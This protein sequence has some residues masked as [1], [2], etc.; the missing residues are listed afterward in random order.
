MINLLLNSMGLYEH[1]LYEH[2][3]REDCFFLYQPTKRSL[4]LFFYSRKHTGS[5]IWLGMNT[6]EERTSNVCIF[7]N[8]DYIIYSSLGSFYIPCCLMIFLYYRIFKEIRKRAKRSHAKSST[9]TTPSSGHPKQNA[10]TKTQSRQQDSLMKPDAQRVTSDKLTKPAAIDTTSSQQESNSDETQTKVKPTQTKTNRVRKF[11]PLVGKKPV[12]KVVVNVTRSEIDEEDEE[13]DSELTGSDQQQAKQSEAAT[14][15]KQPDKKDGKGFYLKK[16]MHSDKNNN[17]LDKKKGISAIIKSSKGDRKTKQNEDALIIANVSALNRNQDDG[18]QQAPNAYPV[19]TSSAS[20]KARRLIGRFA[21]S[22]KLKSEEE[23]TTLDLDYL[24]S[25]NVPLKTIDSTKLSADSLKERTEIE[26]ESSSELMKE[27][28][29]KVINNLFA[30]EDLPR[31][32]QMPA[33]SGASLKPPTS[34]TKSITLPLDS[35]GICVDCGQLSSFAHSKTFDQ[36]LNRK[37]KES[38][39]QNQKM[40][41]IVDIVADFC[42]DNNEVEILMENTNQKQKLIPSDSKSVSSELVVGEESVEILANQGARLTDP[43]EPKIV[44][45][46][47]CMCEHQLAGAPDRSLAL[48]AEAGGQ[49]TNGRPVESGRGDAAIAGRKQ[50]TL[51]TKSTTAV[52]QTSTTTTVTS[53]ITTSTITGSSSSNSV[54][55][56]SAVNTTNGYLVKSAQD[57]ELASSYETAT[58]LTK[59]DNKSSTAIRSTDQLSKKKSRFNLGRKQ[60]NSRKK[61]EKASAKRERKATKTLAIVLGKFVC[62]FSRLLFSSNRLLST[63]GVFLF[64]WVPFFSLNIY[65]AICIKLQAEDCK[66]GKPLEN[67]ES[68]HSLFS[69]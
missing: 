36:D 33:R 66:L 53:T 6:S 5:P 9:G 50:A 12:E 62:A 48:D 59:Q 42:H 37:I 30:K 7:V 64:C 11:I 40:S 51:Q 24:S 22:A 17:Q 14:T 65:D 15:P 18:V 10:D 32:I 28:E 35:A 43:D 19:S 49:R 21:L 45:G 34:I 56:V 31:K 20:S 46:L 26:D 13:E 58:Q 67:L 29:S 1:C 68:R 41:C 23:P 39:D 60:K 8:S 16:I 61:R 69:F 52:I 54:K 25:T 3:L 57:D 38:F 63:P 27:S 2:C 44:T 47:T 55:P 4:L